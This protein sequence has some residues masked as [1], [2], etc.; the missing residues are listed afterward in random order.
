M[1]CLAM[2]AATPWPAMTVVSVKRAKMIIARSVSPTAGS[3]RTL[4]ALAA[5]KTV[6]SVATQRVLRAWLSARIVGIVCAPVV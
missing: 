1:G 2:T 5:W 6:Q 4:I 3:V